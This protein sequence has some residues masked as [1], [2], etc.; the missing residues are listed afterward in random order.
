MTDSPFQLEGYT[1]TG[2]LEG[3]DA[4]DVHLLPPSP[5]ACPV[6]GVIDEFVK[7]GHRDIPVKDLNTHGKLVTL[8][9]DRQRYLCR[10]CGAT[11]RPALPGI[12]DR[13][14][15]TE[16]LLAYVAKESFNSTN[17]DLAAR[18]GLDE[19]TV[20]QVFNER[21][22]QLNEEYAPVTPRVIGID[23]LFL[24]KRYRGII[25]NVEEKTLVDILPSRN[26]AD[27]IDYLRGLKD[28]E[29]IEIATMDMWG[30]YRQAFREVLPSVRIVVDKFHVTRMAND[31]LEKVR[32]HVR[33]SLNPKNRKVLK[34]DRK[35][36][37]KRERD[38][39]P[40]ELLIATG[41]LNNNAELSVAYHLKERF[42][43][44]WEVANTA[45]EAKT[46]LDEWTRA[47]PE[48]Q[49]KFWS[50]L[51]KAVRNWNDEILNFFR[52]DKT[53]T[54]A[55]T[56]SINRRIRDCNR[57]GRGYSFES[58]RGKMLFSTEHK[59][60]VKVARSPFATQGGV[61]THSIMR[62]INDQAEATIED[63]GVDLSTT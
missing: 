46:M 25:T 50:D 5:V 60:R 27:I 21:L 1:V 3:E 31:A 22:T 19:K 24:G 59:K 10:A 41:W 29:N 62:L 20:R 42:F 18:L 56:E 39:L 58:L 49:E 48:S 8:W 7:N 32:K 11:F 4:F 55:L 14:K 54:N 35:I 34:G 15:M 53:V 43:D 28:K 61:W 57:D 51:T 36:L 26:K 23:E 17:K 13:F 12:S 30:P 45:E 37:L 40:Q 6:C 9:I 47:I 52:C 33:L 2:C 44:I 16:R 63:F 38:L